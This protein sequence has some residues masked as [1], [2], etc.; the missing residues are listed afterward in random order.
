MKLV[1]PYNFPTLYVRRPGSDVEEVHEFHHDDP[2]YNELDAFIETAA[3]SADAKPILSS[4]ADCECL[5]CT[6][7]KDSE[8]DV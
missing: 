2:F 8:T 6:A 7:V 1:D 3:G 5:C 4:F